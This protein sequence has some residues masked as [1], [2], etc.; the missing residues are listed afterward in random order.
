[1]SRKFHPSRDKS[2]HKTASAKGFGLPQVSE[3]QVE[4][5]LARAQRELAE[6]W[7]R[8]AA[9]DEVLRVIASS[10]RDLLPVFDTIL[11]NATRLCGANFGSL[12]LRDREVFR[13]AAMHNAPPAYED[14]RRS[15][16]V[17]DPGHPAAQAL[18][19]RLAKINQIFQIT[20]LMSAPPATRGA[21]AKLAGARTVLA[22]PMLKEDELLGAILIYRQEVLPFTEKQI[23]L[24]SNFA[25]Q[26]VIAIENVRLL[27][28]LRHRTADLSE[29]LEQQ[30]ATSEVLQ[31]ISS[32]PG[33]LEPV[34]GT[35][36]ANAVR[37]C[38]AKFG[39]L[40]SLL[41][42]RRMY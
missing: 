28:E 13:I 9:T 21:L 33:A 34:F 25:N 32:S 8:Q 40:N 39:V 10:P 20:D 27:N 29:T 35:M 18:L 4:D 38:E 24:V 3:A 26:A 31:V 41:F 22:V 37:L 19:G 5:E 16:T 36:L 14:L 17:I 30:R 2:R 15:E 7:E 42:S 23:E 6:A 12:Y 11:S 1:V